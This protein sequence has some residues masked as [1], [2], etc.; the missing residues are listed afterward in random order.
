MRK[1]LSEFFGTAFL[2]IFSSAALVYVLDFQVG[3][4]FDAM[5]IFGL[6]LAV[7]MFIFGPFS[8]G[9]HF[10]PAVSLASAI[11][12]DITWKTFGGYILAQILGALAGLGLTVSSLLPV[13]HSQQTASSTSTT[14]TASVTATQLFS[15]FEPSSS[16]TSLQLALTIEAVF[17]FFLVFITVLAFKK[18]AKYSAAIAGMTFAITAFITYPITGGLLNPARV[19]APAVY[20]G[21]ASSAH[22]WFFLIVEIV[23]AA[24]AGYAVKYFVAND[25][26]AEVA[27]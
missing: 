24:L 10:N 19:L 15:S 26:Q 14:S 13:I 2:V 4:L 12:K 20:H 18:Y 7:L 5:A 8:N 21:L 16:T 22:L 1:Y 27:E 23:A 6:S 17:T 11:N 25:A 9:G 3:Q